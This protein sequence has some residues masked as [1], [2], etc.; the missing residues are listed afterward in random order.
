MKK[1]IIAILLSIMM[2]SGSIGAVPVF[3]SQP[4]AVQE[5]ADI[6]AEEDG[7]GFSPESG[8]S[9][10]ED[11]VLVDESAVVETGTNAAEDA[12]EEQSGQPAEEQM[13]GPS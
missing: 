1:S 11:P 12:A 13:V 4:P 10:G 8:S 2:I 5:T 6:L 7:D 3:A 9:A